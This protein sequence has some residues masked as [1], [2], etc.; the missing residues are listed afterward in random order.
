[1]RVLQAHCFYAR[2]G[3]EDAVV[4]A[5]A[6]LLRSRGCDV[7]ELRASNA[8]AVAKGALSAG[9]ALALSAW[10]REVYRRVRRACRRSRPDVLHVHNFWWALSPSIFA[11]AKAEGVATVLTLHNYRLICPGALLMRGSEICEECVGASPWHAVPRRCYRGS[12]ALTALAARMIGVNKRRGTWNRLVDAFIALTEFSRR[13]FVEGGLPSEKIHVKPNFLE[14]DPGQAQD[15]GSGA[16]FVGRLSRE[17]GV[18]VLLE[19]WNHVHGKERLT[20]V[21]DGPQRPHL[22]ARAGNVGGSRIRFMGHLPPE[23]A[24]DCIKRARVLVMPSICYETFGRAIIEAYACGR[25]VVA[26]RLG[27]MAKLIEDGRTGL[28]FKPGNACDLA[29]KTRFMLDKPTEGER[30]GR[31]A[32]A[33]FEKKYT[34]EANYPQLMAVYE[35]V[36]EEARQ[37]KGL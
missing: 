2:S 31:E 5:E 11:A 20:I 8:D 16:V 18:H 3:G 25:P 21:G 13:K 19:G 36:A 32:R 35:R 9:R 15:R 26:S 33:E 14:S 30:M 1:M 6:G 37:R 34:A 22:E 10:N 29:E 24:I 23:Q 27:A 12:A 7:L 28:L 17:K 4:A